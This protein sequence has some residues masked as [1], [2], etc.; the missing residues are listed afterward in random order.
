[1]AREVPQYIAQ[2][3]INSM[4][5]AQ[6]SF[7]AAQAT[8]KMS[9]ELGAIA[10]DMQKKTA[11]METLQ[12]STTM[13]ENLHRIYSES[14]NDPALI[15][16]KTDGFFKEF[17]PN[18][19]NSELQKKLDITKN[20]E[21][22]PYID[23]AF[24]SHNAILDEQ[25][26]TTQLFA[27]NK[28]NVALGEA[29]KAYS[30]ATT[31]EAR[32][33]ALAVMDGLSLEQANLASATDSSG[34]QI[35]APEKQVSVLKD[36]QRTVLDAIPADKRIEVLGGTKAGFENHSALVH[37]HEGGLNVND[38]NTGNPA[39]FGINKKWH[40]A[41]FNEV[42]QIYDTQGYAAGQAAADAYL[43]KT[44][45]DANN[46]D[47]MPA[48]VQGIVYDGVINHH[49]G[50]TK[51]LVAA[52]H[53]GA[54]PSELIDMRQKE[55]NRLA[56]T[57][58]YSKQDVASWNNR[59]ADY[60]HLIL[61]ER[62]DLI[63]SA[64]REKYLK[65]AVDQFKSQEEVANINRVMGAAVKDKDVYEQFINN[66]PDILQTIEDYK[67]NGGDPE[68]ANYMRKSALT[69]NQLSAGEEDQIYSDITDRVLALQE[70]PDLTL[71]DTI[72]LQRDI[73]K[74]SVKGVKKLD[75]YLKKLS[76]AIAELAQK[77]RGKDDSGIDSFFGF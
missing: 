46:I 40:E 76:P 60:Q 24:A 62:T 23:K 69:R 70:K 6:Y 41:A 35:W 17:I 31:P 51:K 74:A 2:L 22:Q 16:S 36:V 21:A 7:G 45:W 27:M 44:F 43:K 64:D 73:M 33:A 63:D 65:E 77:E 1:M 68:L 37:K 72:R 61:G 26:K 32:E 13:R 47:S 8:Q 58:K 39:L 66:S 48:N 14:P 38:G 55:Y 49:Q 5:K 42:K 67:N 20:L 18:I 34:R 71:E 4:P 50:F 52:A 29:A 15:K 12:A 54:P 28:N 9:A 56:A 59:V 10:E 30:I 3:G 19:K 11:E 75:P 53:A 25:Y 57:G